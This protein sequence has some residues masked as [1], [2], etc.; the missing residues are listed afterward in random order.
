MYSKDYNCIIQGVKQ[1]RHYAI[2]CYNW[3]ATL[4]I[5]KKENINV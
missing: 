4:N 1:Q 3:V 2:S 5:T